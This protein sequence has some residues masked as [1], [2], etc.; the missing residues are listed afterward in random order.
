MIAS[1]RPY[2]TCPVNQSCTH[3]EHLGHL[4]CLYTLWPVGLE[5][6]R[7]PLSFFTIVQFGF[8]T[9][10]LCLQSVGSRTCRFNRI[11][12]DSLCE[13]KSSTVVQ[14]LATSTLGSTVSPCVD[15]RGQYNGSTDASHP[16]GPGPPPCVWC[17]GEWYLTWSATINSTTGRLKV[18]HSLGKGMR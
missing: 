17:V 4:S 18:L 6:S 8:V 7:F 2:T 10:W 15:H 14:C 13:H 9:R 1:G 3:M 12:L 11:R 5:K 16:R